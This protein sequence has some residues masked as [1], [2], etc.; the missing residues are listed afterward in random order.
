MPRRSLHLN[1]SAPS[2][3]TIKL[4][5]LSPEL[6]SIENQM[7]QA[8]ETNKHLIKWK[9]KWLSDNNLYS[10]Y[11]FHVVRMQSRLS[12]LEASK[13]MKEMEL[14]YRTGA[15]DLIATGFAIRLITPA[16]T[17][18]K[19][20]IPSPIPFLEIPFTGKPRRSSSVNANART[21]TSY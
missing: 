13:I 7:L 10:P 21:F 12:E 19:E 11:Y 20:D 3:N 8:I 1:I 18:R 16:G 15:Q 5:L 9:K 6:V 2:N 4:N 14:E 17:I